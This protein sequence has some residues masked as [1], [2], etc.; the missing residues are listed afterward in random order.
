[1]ISRL[2]DQKGFDILIQG[3]DELMKMGVQLVCWTGDPKY[4]EQLE[5]WG[6]S[7]LS[8]RRYTDVQQ[9][10]AHRIEAGADMFLMPSRYDR[11]G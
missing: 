4:H 7:I 3:M 11:A 10:M 2:D 1:V 5:K 6:R 9:W 8:R